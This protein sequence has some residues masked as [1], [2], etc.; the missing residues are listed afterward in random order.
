MEIISQ[1]YNF[2]KWISK[3]KSSFEK[4]YKINSSFRI[5]RCM[6]FQRKSRKLNDIRSKKI[7]LIEW[8]DNFSE[9]KWSCFVIS[10]L[11]E[12]SIDYFSYVGI[13]A[14]H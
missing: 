5:R 3:F 14:V 7:K 6:I 1:F 10:Q 8:W 11:P 9:I 12:T 2:N 4:I 13:V